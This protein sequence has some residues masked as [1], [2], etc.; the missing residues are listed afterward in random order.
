MCI[1]SHLVSNIVFQK[2]RLSTQQFSTRFDVSSHHSPKVCLFT[3]RKHTLLLGN[4]DR[5]IIDTL[6]NVVGVLPVNGASNGLGGSEDL[7]DGTGK[8]LGKGLVLH[9]SGDLG[10]V[11][12]DGSAF[13]SL[14]S[15]PTSRP[16]LT[17]TIS[18]KETLPVCLM[19]FS[20][21]RSRGG[22]FKALMTK[23]DAEGTTLTLA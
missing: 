2:K 15:A 10:T 14:I 1:S 12:D 3:M 23:L 8:V 16:L 7:L 22:S 21:F 4:L 19:F 13:S 20:F 6:D 11:G 17:E 9:L 5:T 18:S